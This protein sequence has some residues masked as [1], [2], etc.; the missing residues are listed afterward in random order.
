MSSLKFLAWLS[1]GWLCKTRTSHGIL[2]SHHLP[3]THCQAL[4]I[5]VLKQSVSTSYWLRLHPS[6]ASRCLLPGRLP[7]PLTWC[8]ISAAIAPCH[9]IFLVTVT[10]ILLKY[11]YDH[12]A[13]LLHLLHDFLL[14]LRWRPKPQMWPRKYWNVGPACCI[15]LISNH[16]TLF[17]SGSGCSVHLSRYQ[18]LFR[19]A[20]FAHAFSMLEML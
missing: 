8:Y 1:K 4:L 19:R 20:S 17:W 5:L 13:V 7:R 15:S 10:Q 14:L 3:A 12:V 16:F 9:L 18:I 6:S 2:S 11:T